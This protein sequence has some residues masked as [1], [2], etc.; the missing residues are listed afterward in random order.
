MKFLWDHFN[1]F[2]ELSESDFSS[3][4]HP[5]AIVSVTVLMAPG[6]YIEPNVTISGF[7]DIG[8]ASTINRAYNIG[9][10]T[11]I[12]AYSTVGPG[13]T[14][15]GYISIGRN[16]SIGAGAVVFDN[17]EIGDNCIIGGG[18]V[19]TKSIPA[20]SLAYGNPCK[21]ARTIDTDN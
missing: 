19:V 2:G 11:V 13:A 15:C 6:V 5:S 21:I 1:A 14:I 9:H 10:H 7:A 17:L 18:S 3:I 20:N 16:V 4:V 8:F 12:D